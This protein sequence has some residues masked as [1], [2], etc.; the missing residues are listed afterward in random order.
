MGGE[1]VRRS[2]SRDRGEGEGE[3][4]ERNPTPLPATEEGREE[5]ERAGGMGE[6]SM[7]VET[8]NAATSTVKP[9]VA[10][11]EWEARPEDAVARRRSGR[12]VLTTRR[13]LPAPTGA[14][15]WMEDEEEVKERQL[16][17]KRLLEEPL[18]QPGKRRALSKAKEEEKKDSHTGTAPPPLPAAPGT[19][20]AGASSSAVSGGAMSAFV[21]PSVSGSA[22]A[23]DGGGSSR[24]AA[25]TL[26]PPASFTFGANSTTSAA[27]APASSA[28]AGSGFQFPA[29]SSTMLSTFPPTLTQ[30]PALPST[31][32]ASFSALPSAPA[33]FPFASPAP[34]IAPPGFGLSGGAGVGGGPAFNPMQGGV[35]GGQ[36]FMPAQPFGSLPPQQGMQAQA[37][38][39]EG[40]N[41]GFRAPAKKPSRGGRGR[42]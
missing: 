19:E 22:A 36:G 21:S 24:Q 37:S 1:G 31:P 10:G 23:A 20:V 26:P 41:A 39:G 16:R 25:S 32:S 11:F 27:A 5:G 8:K 30:A 29:A 7:A 14:A 17:I 13:S 35:G 12:G 6:V 9:Q 3:G 28:A 15:V 34:S 38:A 40:F 42:K 33:P 18:P 2:A 4:G